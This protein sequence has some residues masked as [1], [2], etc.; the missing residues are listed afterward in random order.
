[1]MWP[2]DVS[3]WDVLEF[4]RSRPELAGIPI[5]M[6]TGRSDAEDIDKPKELGADEF[7]H[8]PLRPDE[9]RRLIVDWIY[10]TAELGA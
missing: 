7:L 1:M 2:P 4:L 9:L 8:K 3:G 5:V 10:R 6:L